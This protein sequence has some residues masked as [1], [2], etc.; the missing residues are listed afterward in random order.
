MRSQV[1]QLVLLA[2][3]LGAGAAAGQSA[4]PDLLRDAA[5]AYQAG[6]VTTAIRLYREFLKD[7]PNAAEIRS[8]LGAALVRNGQFAEAIQE[9][10]AALER[11]P[12]NPHVRMNL[13][14]AYYKLGRLAEAV[15]E[16]E[17]LRKVQPLEVKPALLL[18]D[19]LMQ[20]GQSGKVVDLLT[21]FE[22]EYPDDRAVVFALGM[23]LLEQNH[24]EQAQVLLD[25]ILRD[26][27]SAESE[28]LLGQMEYQR[29][30]NLEAARRLERA[31]KLNPKLP[32]AH[33][34][35]GVV[36]RD[37][38]KPDLAAEQFREELKGNPYDFPANIQ[39][40]MIA[41]QDGRLEEALGYI[42]RA[43]EVRPADPGALYQRASIH[44]AQGLTEQA[45]QEFEQLVRDYPGFAEAHAALATV[46][47][48]LRR[49]A[50]GDRE[51]AA[52]L[53]AQ[54]EAQKQLEERRKRATQPEAPPRQPENQ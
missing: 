25:R 8:N 24:T 53:R 28:F 43:L 2:L 48:R 27:E 41:K 22:Q 37:I 50:D 3:S 33:S 12:N 49:T 26:G 30:N 5:A 32:G 47:Y 54:E 11:L 40:A 20:T 14:L 51:R 10:R 52:A 19:C 17:A 44:L 15:Q 7:Y 46:Y 21:P 45:R 36:L 34:M 1:R 29:Q 38:G 16:L 23:A 39:T 18:A 9:Y 31:V 13:A 42:E 35:Y 4:P 6:E